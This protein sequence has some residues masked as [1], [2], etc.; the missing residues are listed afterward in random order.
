MTSLFLSQSYKDT[1]DDYNRSLTNE[2]FSCWDYVVL[3]ASNE[4]QAESFRAQIRDRQQANFLPPRTRF[5]VIPDEGGKRVGSGGATLSAVKA[6]AL[7]AKT[8][9]F[10]GLKILVIHSGG[11]LRRLR[12][13]L[14]H[15][16]GSWRCVRLCTSCA[17]GHLH[18]RPPAHWRARYY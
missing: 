18:S 8:N 1:W 12:V 6:I 16:F 7:D 4:H 15:L 13:P 3:T 9:D 17:R 5:I 10:S 14:R 11:P 2:N